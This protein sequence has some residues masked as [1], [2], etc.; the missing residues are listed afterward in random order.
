MEH[1]R[2]LLERWTT[3][4]D[5]EALNEIVTR[6][7]NMVYATSLRVLGNAPDAEVSV[8]AKS[9]SSGLGETVASM[10]TGEDGRYG[11]RLPTGDLRITAGKLG[12]HCER[13]VLAIEPG[14]AALGPRP[15]PD[16]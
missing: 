15:G 3:R 1:D 4:R 16:R 2:I 6:H 11:L 10:K 7:M 8:T 9:P 5:A 14:Q 13:Q 12:Y